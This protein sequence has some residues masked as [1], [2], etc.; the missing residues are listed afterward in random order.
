MKTTTAPIPLVDLQ[1]Q[2]RS[3]K[4]D[5]DATIADVIAESAFVGTAGNRFVQAF[6]AQFARFVGARA[7]VAC[8]NGTDS[9]EILLKAAGIG[10]GDEV[11]VPAV[12]WIS[13]SEAVSA[14][15]ATP[16]FVDV[17]PGLYSMDP[18]LAAAKVTSRTRA[19]VRCTYTGCR[20]GWTRSA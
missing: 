6:E 16:V 1:A 11:L 10:P 9:L 19:I 12:S 3:I 20:R 8:G 13:T 17:L 15:A 18:N 5:I 4:S 7:C 14:C 2:Y